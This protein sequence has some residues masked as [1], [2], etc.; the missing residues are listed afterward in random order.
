M[1]STQ[2]GFLANYLAALPADFVEPR[3]LIIQFGGVEFSLEPQAVTESYNKTFGSV[4]RNYRVGAT[5]LQTFGGQ[6]TEAY[7]LHYYAQIPAL[8][9]ATPQNWLI[10][11]RP[12]IYLYATLLEAA[13]YLH[14]DARTTIWG[15][16]YKN[17][18]DALHG[19]DKRAKYKNARMRPATAVNP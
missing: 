12:Q 1:D 6:G 10:L 19:T 7:T 3:S 8:S 14:D 2:T 9:G 16:G 13:P 5:S 11:A 18:C 15:T 17:A 4:P